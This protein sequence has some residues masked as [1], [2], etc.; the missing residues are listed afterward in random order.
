MFL[1]IIFTD[2]SMIMEDG[3]TLFYLLFEKDFGCHDNSNDEHTEMDF[4]CILCQWWIKKWIKTNERLIRTE[5]RQNPFILRIF[6]I[7]FFLCQCTCRSKSIYI[8]N[9]SL[10]LITMIMI[11]SL[12]RL[13]STE[14]FLQLSK[15][16]L[17]RFEML[18]LQV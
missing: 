9:H 13:V 15:K 10:H 2:K 16:L 18:L 1:L 12:I 14:L 8:F 11:I 3:T 6:L 7:Y 5:N 17:K 4:I